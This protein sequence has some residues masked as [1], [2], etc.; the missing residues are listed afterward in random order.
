MRLALLDRS[1]RLPPPH[2]SRSPVR[3]RARPATVKLGC[4]HEGHTRGW[5][6]V[7]LPAA[8]EAAALAALHGT[9]MCAASFPGAVLA[10][11]RITDKRDT[12]FPCLS[13]EQRLQLRLDPVALHSV[14]DSVTADRS[15]LLIDTLMQL[16]RAADAASQE[17]DAAV[18]GASWRVT[19]GCAC[20]GGSALSFARC[21]RV[22]HV[23]AVESDARRAGALAHN[24]A[25][26]GLADAR[27]SV[28]HG[29]FIEQV[30]ASAAGAD[31]ATSAAEDVLFLDPPWLGGT[32]Y[33]A[34]KRIEAHE[35]G[36]SGVPLA[37]LAAAA[38]RRGAGVAA[39]STPRNYDDTGLARALTAVR[40]GE[41]R[42]ADRALPFRLE[43]GA[44]VLLL[45]LFPPPSGELD[46]SG[47][48]DAGAM[49]QAAP[50]FSFPTAR[51]DGA[52][53]QRNAAGWC[54]CWV[55]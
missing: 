46:A 38:R 33:S 5:A 23:L 25:V 39:F 17:A 54:A 34:A 26:C 14:M 20:V 9:P 3:L 7:T 19:D 18:G 41:P 12:L 53:V 31:S 24:A 28:R 49:P 35:L 1:M 37:A 47:D 27:L 44:R 10:L 52:C 16:N 13:R 32:H 45:A 6:H 8:D 50:R 21:A 48:A 51:L 11:A 22:S 30:S 43:M 15:T 42:H 4:T 2:L 55:S 40:P 29:D 36:L